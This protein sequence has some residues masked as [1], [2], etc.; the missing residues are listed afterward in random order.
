[1]LDKEHEQIV[2]EGREYLIEEGADVG[3]L[4]IK[5]A[6]EGVAFSKLSEEEQSLITDYSNIFKSESRDRMQRV[7]EVAA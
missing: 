6:E 3:R 4:L 2:N 5:C 7:L 1:M